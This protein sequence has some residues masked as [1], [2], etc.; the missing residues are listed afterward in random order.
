MLKLSQM[1]MMG[2]G[3]L[4]IWGGIFS[5]AFDE[6]ATNENFLVLFVGGLASFAVSVA[7]IEMQSKKN[8]HHLLD[9]QNYILG[10]AFFF[11]TVG[12]LW[13]T[14][15]AVGF[16]TGVL[17][18]DF[19]GD[20][21]SYTETDWSPNANAIYAQ[22]LTCLLLTYGHYRLLQR[23][24]GQTSFGWGVATYAPMAILLAGVGPWIRWSND[25]VSWELGIAML[26]ITL[27]SL[28][29]SLRSNKALN[30]V[31]VAFVAGLVPLV[32]EG[33]NTNAPADGAGGALSLMVFVIAIQG[34][35]A[36][37][38][39]LRKEVMERASLLLIGQIVF[40]LFLVRISTNE[41]NLILGPFRAGDYP[42]LADYINVPVAL[43][44]TVLFA[45]FPAVLKQRVPWMPIGLAGALVLIPS[46][47]STVPWVLSMLILPYMVFISKVA[48]T[49]VVNL[50]MLAF[51]A[52]YLLTDWYAYT[53]DIP[54][55]EAF[56][57]TWLHVL[58]PVFLLAVAELGR[59]QQ[60]LQT[61]ITLAMIGAVVL[62][63]AILDPEWYLPWLLVA[64]MFFL[65]WNTLQTAD[66]QRVQHRKDAT[67]A[68][69]FTT[70]TVILLAVLDNLTL[71]EVQAIER[72]VDVGFRPQFL[73]LSIAFYVLSARGR[74]VEF[75][76]GSLL[77][78]L[79][80]GNAHAPR[81]D[82]E[83][84]TWVVKSVDEVDK[85]QS[86][87]EAAWG[88]LARFSVVGWLM[89]FTFSIN[90]L[91]VDVWG[92][93]PFI[94]LLLALPVAML[95]REFLRMEAIGS[96]DRATGVGLLIFLAVPLAWQL[97]DA[98]W[99]GVD[100]FGASVLL[101][102][103]LVTAPLV[104][105]AVIQRRG[106][107]ETV[108]NREADGATYL[109]LLGLALLDTSG[110][111]LFLPLA[112]LVAW[113]TV[114]HRYHA[115][116]L[117]VPL[118]A[119]LADVGRDANGLVGRGLEALP[120]NVSDYLASDHNGPFQAY[121]GIFVAVHMLAQLYNMYKVEES[122]NE[123]ALWVWGAILWFTLA[124]LSILPDGYWIPTLVVLLLMPYLYAT[125][126]SD[127]LPYALGLL[128]VA[129]FFG[130]SFSNTFQPISDGDAA[131][132]SGVLT[133]ATGCLMAALHAKGMLF[134]QAAENEEELR[135][136]NDV[137]QLSIQIGGLGFVAGYSVFYGLGPVMGLA[138][139]TWSMVRDGKLGG[140]VL[141]PLLSTF[142]V[143]NILLQSELGSNDQRTTIAGVALAVQGVMLT[144]L[145]A[146]DDL[147]YD[148]EGASWPS[149][150]EFFAFMDRLGLA[151]LAYSLI[152]VYVALN[153]ADLDSAAF[154]LMTVYLVVIGVQ[155]FDEENDAVWR[156]GLGGYGSIFT[157]FLFANSLENAL[158]GAI[159]FV[160][161][162]IVALGFGFLFMQRMNE[163]DGIFV[164]PEEPIAP[165][166]PSEENGT[167]A[168][169]KAD[170]DDGR[171][172]KDEADDLES[173]PQAEDT[174]VEAGDETEPVEATSAWEATAFLERLSNTTKGKDAPLPHSGLLSTAE[175]FSVRLPSDAVTKI[176]DT[177]NATP[178]E[179]YLPVV[180]FGPT[181]EIMLTFEEDKGVLS[182]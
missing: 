133:G 161:M 118:A 71:P 115:I 127:G 91:R 147:V 23:Y 62:S 122:E 87:T 97:N 142:S 178:H 32:Y 176:L 167:E 170:E 116:T 85:D 111:I 153:T 19:F 129:L 37:R 9:I 102:A 89:M 109:L 177:L 36:A 136:Q 141:F 65:N 114:R 92:T 84:G 103:V 174:E 158:F 25:V 151:G 15:Y 113:R 138:V 49:W 73:V 67:L 7:L 94:V 149:D 59:S 4:A 33:L 150:N 131:G 164:G 130:F 86:I 82:A 16:A 139:L 90:L 157:S 58:I 57:G 12:V 182:N 100:V 55:K 126:R 66:I 31:V 39:D 180:A 76:V 96:T 22:T 120:Q 159:G 38:Q 145:S 17:E 99:M 45:Y 162:G 75:D 35:F 6:E 152:G 27:V 20:P 14:R 165:S 117:F 51:S 144:F 135:Q 74:H 46:D 134:K 10:I 132:W 13:G 125:N 106:I 18:L 171:E 44:C 88:P 137:A 63:R 105:N 52:S 140:I 128:F 1:V 28:E 143:V 24:K 169:N 40:A 173:K 3:F 80:Q 95:V 8:E 41:F 78:W 123:N 70:F 154:L 61:S 50:T 175:G 112:V 81:Y 124:L 21:T 60:R 163:D 68:M 64:Y 119:W 148:F 5:V 69:L 155:G 83:T 181:G 172:Q 160:L 107:D 77:K 11:S 79:D 101:D 93:S 26:S 2:I 47:A 48:R 34:Y 29:M 179:G 104:V 146:K 72:V 54:A 110:G 56:G 168:L 98:A 166:D 42:A 53:Q 108:L 43:W 30:F 121:L 156:R